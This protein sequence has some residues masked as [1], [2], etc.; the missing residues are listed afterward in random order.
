MNA[1]LPFREKIPVTF[2]HLTNPGFPEFYPA[3]RE[4]LPL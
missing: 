4:F 2:Y 1:L 3:L